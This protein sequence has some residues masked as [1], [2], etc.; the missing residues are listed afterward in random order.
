[1]T[2]EAYGAMLLA[3]IQAHKF[4][5]E[6]ARERGVAGAVGFAFSVGADGE[7]R[8]VTIVKSSGS[9]ELDEAVRKIVR[10]VSAPPP[11]GGSFSA[12]TTMVFRID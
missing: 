7:I 1:M 12:N 6:G 4:Y 9:P 8:S 10:S 3:A 11:P 2:R 5:P